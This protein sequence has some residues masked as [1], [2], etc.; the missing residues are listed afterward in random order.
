MKK[1]L[2][3]VI[4]FAISAGSSA[5]TEERN[6]FLPPKPDS[7]SNPRSARMVLLDTDSIRDSKPMRFNF[8]NSSELVTF[9]VQNESK[10]GR[11]WTGVTSSGQSVTF[12]QLPEG[13]IV[14]E[15]GDDGGYIIVPS[16]VS[17]NHRVVT[18]ADSA[19][20]EFSEQRALKRHRQIL[21]VFTL[22][23][24]NLTITGPK[25]SNVGYIS[26]KGL[27]RVRNDRPE[28]SSDAKD[29]L[30]LTGTETFAFE[31][32]ESKRSTPQRRY[33]FNQ[34]V[35][36][37][38]NGTTLK[39]TVEDETGEITLIVGRVLSGLGLP[40]HEAE[41]VQSNE[42]EHLAFEALKLHL[43][44]TSSDTFKVRESHLIYQGTSDDEVELAWQLTIDSPLGS[45]TKVI[46]NAKTRES[47]VIVIVAGHVI[48]MP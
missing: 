29:A 17:G 35:N 24:T 3:M 10:L 12:S 14:G 26:G 25:T 36:G 8:G 38:R 1:A 37:V 31:K 47:R 20:L 39:L 30:M 16:G 40:T 33:Y 7:Q 5:K 23:P 13:R 41:D 2:V 45:H 32:K 18:K 42:A 48:Y 34:Y 22:S 44:T 9:R 19:S 43:G 21:A 27:G 15:I 11:L 46:V 6:G 28:L 4:L